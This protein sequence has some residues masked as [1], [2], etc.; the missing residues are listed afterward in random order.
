[1]DDQVMSSNQ[2]EPNEGRLAEASSSRLTLCDDSG[3]ARL[4]PELI[5]RLTRSIS[6]EPDARLVLIEGVAGS[7]CEGLDL[8]I[9]TSHRNGAAAPFSSEQFLKQFANLLIALERT[10]RPVLALVDGPALGGGVGLAAVADLVL[11]SPQ[12]SFA[13]PETLVGLIPAMVFPYIARRI[14]MPRARLL[15]L[16]GEP[17][18][19]DKALQWGLVD[20]IVEDFDYALK[21]HAA[22]LSRMDVRAQGEMKNLIAGHF[23]ATDAYMDDAAATFSDLLASEETRDR[24]RRFAAGETPWPEET[25]P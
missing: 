5:E 12:A 3:R 24:L 21:R 20:E 2:G 23:G 22:R 10:P 1:M 11:A 6:A 19:A 4:T 16:G 8:T 14:G 25:A 18:S 9:L 13:L 15:A 7:F 17:L